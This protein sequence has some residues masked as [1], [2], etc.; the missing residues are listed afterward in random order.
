[1]EREWY[2]DG[3]TM[4]EQQELQR[5][6]IK[7]KCK[8]TE[9]FQAES[10]DKLIT[11]LRRKLGESE[12]YI[13]ELE[14]TNKKLEQK[15]K[16]S[17]AAFLGLQAANKSL[18][19]KYSRDVSELLKTPVFEKIHAEKLELEKQVKKLEEIRDQLIYRLNERLS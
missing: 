5:N 10:A 17:E 14:E 12:S 1:M 4:E 19:G 7:I 6:S 2:D 13:S 18:L 9:K 16:R 3:F 11:E 15:L 8:L